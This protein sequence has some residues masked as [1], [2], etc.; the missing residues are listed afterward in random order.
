MWEEGIATKTQLYLFTIITKLIA[1]NTDRQQK[2]KGETEEDNN[3]M[4]IYRREEARK[5]EI[6]Y[7]E[8]HNYIQKNKTKNKNIHNNNKLRN[9]YTGTNIHLTHT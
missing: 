4:E 2:G 7:T 6:K 1:Y 5:N 9:Y 3:Y 8:E